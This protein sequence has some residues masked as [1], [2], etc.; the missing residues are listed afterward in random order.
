MLFNLIFF[1]LSIFSF[2]FKC[3]HDKIK[4]I[5]KIANDSLIENNK[6]R[7]DDTFHPI[8]FFVDYSQMDNDS[9][10][11]TYKNYLKEVINSTL[12]IFSELIKVK[13]TKNLKFT[14]PRNCSSRITYY[15]NQ[16]T[17]GID[18]DIVLFPIID[19]TLEEGVDAAASS[20]FLDPSNK[21]PIMGYVLLNQNYSYTKNN[22]K[23]YLIML[24][25]HEITHVLVFSDGLYPF[26]NYQGDVT[27]KKEINGLNR[28]LI[29]TPKVRSIAAQHFNCY[30]IDGV[31]LENQGGEGS[32]GS[33][34]E[35]RVMLGDYMLST[36]YLEIVISDISL[37][38]FEDSGWY[39]VNYYTGGLFRFGKGQGCKFLN[40]PCVSQGESNFELDF[41]DTK[42]LNNLCSSNN[43]FRGF[44]YLLQYKSAISSYYQ[45]FNSSYIGGYQ[46]ADYCPV[47]TDYD[48]DDSFFKSSCI[49]GEISSE[50]N[51]YPSSLGFSIS[52]S[53]ICFRSSLINASDS[54]LKNY[55]YKRSMCHQ[56]SCNNDTK[57]IIVDIGQSRIECPTNGG[58]MQVEGYNGTIL[59]PPFNRVCTSET[60]TGDPIEA[61]LN[62]IVNSDIDYSYVLSDDNNEEEN[63]IY[64]D[65]H[66]LEMCL[67]KFILLL[68]LYFIN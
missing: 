21:R 35:G 49:Y 26:F 36:D 20:C 30:S 24:L 42:N 25:L 56:I 47:T 67:Y 46:P 60:Y 61:A 68:F 33:H 16:L 19:P 9:A 41:C 51:K 7:L 15:D 64:E 6:R 59:C 52:E 2:S 62:H 48:S 29:I 55:A 38:L 11:S 23:D 34:W 45:Y 54:S 63:D 1:S 31:E 40:S 44:C 65:S 3:G 53:S 37:A 18:Y 13:R 66:K 14:N 12:E 22:S 32:E 28:T 5:P 50:E 58:E 43:L 57:T 17:T 39:E 27:T 8:S 4:Q 10:N